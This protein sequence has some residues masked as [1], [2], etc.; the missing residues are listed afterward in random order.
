MTWTN[1]AISMAATLAAQIALIVFGFAIERLRPARP[2]GVRCIR[3]NIDCVAV[4]PVTRAVS[5]SIPNA[6]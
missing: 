4:L 1:S 5:M 3:P 6:K 2:Q